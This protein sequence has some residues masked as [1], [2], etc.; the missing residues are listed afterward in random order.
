MDSGQHEF[1]NWVCLAG[2]MSELGHK[3][4]IVDYVETYVFNSEKCLAIFR[5]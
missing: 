4:D 3:A 1:L 2:A 5:P